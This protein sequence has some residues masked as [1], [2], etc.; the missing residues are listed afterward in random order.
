MLTYCLYFIG[1]DIFTLSD[2]GINGTEKLPKTI[3][4]LRPDSNELFL[5]KKTKGKDAENNYDV[6]IKLFLP[7]KKILP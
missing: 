4:Q 7:L 3:F 6:A 5:T 2:D 1:L